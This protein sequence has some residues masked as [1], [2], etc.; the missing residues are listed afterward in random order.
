ML[1][2]HATPFLFRPLPGFQSWWNWSLPK[3][4]IWGV[5][6]KTQLSLTYL[7]RYMILESILLIEICWEIYRFVSYFHQWQSFAVPDSLVWIVHGIHIWCLKLVNEGLLILARKTLAP[8]FQAP[9]QESESESELP[10]LDCTRPTQVSWEEVSTFRELLA[11][12]ELQTSRIFPWTY[13][14]AD[15]QTQS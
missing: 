3:A 4:P 7:K 9:A 5:H 8:T 15:T 6:Q 2:S 13:S 11:K 1:P 10:M 12:K 14:N